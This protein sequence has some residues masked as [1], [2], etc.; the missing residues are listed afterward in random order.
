MA[1]NNSKWLSYFCFVLFFVIDNDM[2]FS[3]FSD[4][5]FDVKEWV[6]SALRIR[7]DRTPIDVSFI[8]CKLIYRTN[9]NVSVHSSCRH[10]IITINRSAISRNLQLYT[11]KYIKHKYGE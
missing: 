3:K 7:D 6:N 10:L 4:D 5:N 11:S 1:A 2:D 8:Y 9:C